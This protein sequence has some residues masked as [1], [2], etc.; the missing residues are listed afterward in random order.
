MWNR[1][2][3][4][5]NCSSVSLE[6]HMVKWA[7]E[8][9]SNFEQLNFWNAKVQKIPTLCESISSSDSNLTRRTIHTLTSIAKQNLLRHRNK[10]PFM[11]MSVTHLFQE[12]SLS[13]SWLRTI[14]VHSSITHDVIYQ[15]N[16][17]K[18]SRVEL[19]TDRNM[20]DA[21]VRSLHAD[22]DFFMCQLDQ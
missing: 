3:N 14:L 15:K 7:I 12:K 8:C 19:V 13:F 22:L 9:L 6:S 5:K 20:R 17:N 21:R 10:I 1:Q 4:K 18:S 2:A 16:T 11:L